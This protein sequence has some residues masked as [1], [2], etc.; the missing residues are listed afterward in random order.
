VIFTRIIYNNYSFSVC[1][2]SLYSWGLNSTK[3][4]VARGSVIDRWFC[5]P[6]LLPFV[7]HHAFL[8]LN[9]YFLF[10]WLFIPQTSLL[11]I[12][13]VYNFEVFV[14]TISLKYFLKWWPSKGMNPVEPLCVTLHG[15]TVTFP[16]NINFDDRFI[17]SSQTQMYTSLC[18]DYRWQWYSCE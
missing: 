16:N 7:S 2:W 4:C 10:Q 11:D 18:T 8:L 15:E 1:S 5:P 9:P 12:K 6:K 17:L 14:A 3:M 13:F